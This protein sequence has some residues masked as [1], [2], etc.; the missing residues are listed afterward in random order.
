MNKGKITL[1]MKILETERMVL[2]QSSIDDA[3]LILML[4][5][6]PSFIR[7][8]GDRGVR[9]LDEARDYILSRLKAS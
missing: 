8:I 7:N 9:T 3:G 1:A 2:R 5:N 6:K 4:L